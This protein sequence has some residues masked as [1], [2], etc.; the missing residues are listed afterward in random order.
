MFGGGMRQAG[1][2]A[3]AG[4]YA[5]EHNRERL[6]ED[7]RRAYQLAESLNEV[8]GLQVDLNL[9]QTNMIYLRTESSAEGVVKQLGEEG[10]DVLAI[11]S[12]LI[13]LVTH[14]HIGDEDIDNTIY[15]FRKVFA[16]VN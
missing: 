8:D 7:H 11:E 1:V 9:V 13:R 14:L 10:I 15:A 2:L 12:N 4:L 16:P 6:M 3:A 5:L